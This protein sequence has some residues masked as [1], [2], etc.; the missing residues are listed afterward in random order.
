VPVRCVAEDVTNQY[1]RA[2]PQRARRERSVGDPRLGDSLVFVRRRF[3]VQAGIGTANRRRP[4]FARGWPRSR[5]TC[6]PDGQETDASRHVGGLRRE[7]ETL[8]CACR[9]AKAWPRPRRT[10]R[11][12]RRPTEH[13]DGCALSSRAVTAPDHFFFPCPCAST[14]CSPASTGM[15]VAPRRRGDHGSIEH[16]FDTKFLVTPIT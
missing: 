1:V 10:R 11:R 6:H 3:L 7:F 4:A 15:G 2:P 13:D 8:G 5:S 14:T 12:A 9:P 16:H